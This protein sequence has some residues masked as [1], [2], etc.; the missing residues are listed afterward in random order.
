MNGARERKLMFADTI[1][2]L[3]YL[4]QV[5]DDLKM[6]MKS[7]KLLRVLWYWKKKYDEV[8]KYVIQWEEINLLV[9]SYE[10]KFYRIETVVRDFV[11]SSKMAYLILAKSSAMCIGSLF[12]PPVMFSRIKRDRF[13]LRWNSKND[14][15]IL[16]RTV[17]I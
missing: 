12:Q 16:T 5:A 17:R 14:R 3:L 13:I 9:I 15:L 11:D 1:I 6:E 4:R 7:G 10:W 2:I 8:E